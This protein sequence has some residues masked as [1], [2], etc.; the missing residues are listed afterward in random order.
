MRSLTHADIP[1][2]AAL[3]AACFDIAWEEAAFAGL[4]E[5]GGFGFGSE[6]CFILLRSAAT[7]SEILTLATHPAHRRQGLARQLLELACK[8]LEA[9]GIEEIFLEVR[10]DNLAAQRFYESSG[11]VQV[12]LRPHYYTLTDGSQKAARVLRKQIRRSHAPL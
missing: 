3:H 9:E 8:Q 11:F 1:A 2:L 12:A 5:S 7:E 4:L 6:S 10:E